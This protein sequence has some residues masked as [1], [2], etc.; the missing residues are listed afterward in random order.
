MKYG[1][2]THIGVDEKELTNPDTKALHSN[3]LT[4]SVTK[5]ITAV[6]VEDDIGNAYL[7]VDTAGWGDSNGP[8]VD[9]ANG[10]SMISGIQKAKSVRPVFIVS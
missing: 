6:N 3:P 2:I 7:L 8:E 10:V 1:K 4:A 5:Y 9:I